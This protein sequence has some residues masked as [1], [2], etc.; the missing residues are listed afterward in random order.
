MDMRSRERFLNYLQA[1][2]TFLPLSL[3]LIYSS[4]LISVARHNSSFIPKLLSLFAVMTPEAYQNTYKTYKQGTKRITTGLVGQARNCG[5]DLSF[6][7]SDNANTKPAR[8]DN[9]KRAGKKHEVPLHQFTDLARTISESEPKVKIPRSI[10]R[11]LRSV[12]SLRQQANSFFEKLTGTKTSGTLKAAKDGHEYFVTVLQQVLQ[13]LSPVGSE[14][15]N[16]PSTNLFVAL[17]VEDAEETD[18]APS[19]PTKG[20]ESVEYDL[21]SSS[22]ESVLAILCSSRTSTRYEIM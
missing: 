3:S 6:L 5:A 13:I 20:V 21:E 19:R 14:G 15:S 22:M 8:L 9:T 12:I 18:A 10:V 7:D 16:E 17:S 2:D 1:F 11:L 4:S